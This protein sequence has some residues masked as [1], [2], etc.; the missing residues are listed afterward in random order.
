MDQKV[1]KDE[2]KVV[3]SGA[4]TGG[5]KRAKKKSEPGNTNRLRRIQSE[6]VQRGRTGNATARTQKKEKSLLVKDTKRR[7]RTSRISSKVNSLDPT[8]SKACRS[9]KK[10]R[11]G[12]LKRRLNKKNG[13][14]A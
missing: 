9:G 4:R 2:K 7:R 8:K 1:K 12:N 5:E 10:R 14:S 3:V 13:Y 6:G 11:G